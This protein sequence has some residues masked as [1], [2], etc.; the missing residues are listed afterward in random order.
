MNRRSLRHSAVFVVL[1]LVGATAGACKDDPKPDPAAS[2]SAASSAPSATPEVK[3]PGIDTSPLLP[4]ERKE[5]N[6]YVTEFLSP[7]ADVAVPIAQCITEK[8][9]CP[10]CTTAAKFLLKA[11]RAGYPREE[12]EKVYKNRFD[13]KEVKILPVDG[14][15]TLGPESA[16]ITI[17][18]F[19]DFEC[20][21]CAMEYPI[22]DR[23]VTEERKDKVRLVY[24]VKLLGHPHGEIAARAAIAAG[25][26]GKFWEMH[27]KLFDNQKA[28]EQRDIEGYAKAIGLDVPK[29]LADMKSKAVGDAIEK[30]QKMAEAL[31]ISKTPT[32]FVN[33]REIEP[34][35]IGDYIAEELGET[36]K[37]KGAPSA[38]GGPA[39]SALP[40]ASTPASASAAP[41][42]SVKPSPS[43]S[44]KGK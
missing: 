15:P 10:G 21:F 18:E 38:S 16:P 3:L 17:V 14:S 8:R 40:S 11:V 30:D 35:S 22:L 6:A 2:A 43:G 28:L 29:L 34:D 32:V 23:L 44:A 9:A 19:A 33:G 27:H 31:G 4:R 24:K 37:P 25:L 20:P 7:C 12:I 5:F 26:Q 36:P 39:L 41:S 42:A 1:A 13:P